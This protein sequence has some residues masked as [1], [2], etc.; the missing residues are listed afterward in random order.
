[1]NRETFN[2]QRVEYFQVA[3]RVFAD[4]PQVRVFDMASKLCG[5]EHCYSVIDNVLIYRD[6]AHL[7][8]D[9][10]KFIGNFM[11]PLIKEPLNQA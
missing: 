11:V 8:Y 2:K 4:Y 10:S 7:G 9:G 1:M 5:A 3:N 6:S